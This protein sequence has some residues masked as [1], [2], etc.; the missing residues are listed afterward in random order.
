[1]FLC[2]ERRRNGTL[3]PCNTITA[4]SSEKRKKTRQGIPERP[5]SGT[6]GTLLSAVIKEVCGTGD[7][8]AGLYERDARNGFPD[9]MLGVKN[10]ALFYVH[11]RSS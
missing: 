6:P 8:A 7:E 1:M 9:D 11:G 10:N 2:L 4:C 3:E 5:S